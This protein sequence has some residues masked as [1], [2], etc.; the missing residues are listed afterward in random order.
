[1]SPRETSTGIVLGPR[2]TVFALLTAYPFL[3]GFLLGY[4]EAF[5]RLGVPG[6][7]EGWARKVTLGD[8]ALDM[9]VT[10][11]RL[12]REIGD[13]VIRVSGRAA[14]VVGSRGPVDEND[15]RLV[16]I[17]RIAVS[18]EAGGSLVELAGDLRDVTAGMDSAEALALE[19]TLAGAVGEA[20]GAADRDVET[21]AGV[22]ADAAGSQYPRGHPVDTLRREAVMVRRLCADLRAELERLGGSASKRRWRASRSLVERLVRRLSEVEQRYRRQQQAWFPALAV[23]GIEGPAALLGDRQ[24]EA[25][26]SLRRLRLAVSG[27]DAAFVVDTGTRLL[28]LLEDLLSI[29]EQVLVPLAERRLAPGDWAAVREMEDG[30]GW[31]LIPA[32]P[33]WPAS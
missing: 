4:D 9:N 3:D 13:E 20:R 5:R 32:P 8:V 30:L 17:R 6:G 7:R 27:D 31:S 16:E 14:A 22:S 18:L 10:W 23:L 25:L 19:R 28:D 11:R 21:A 24:A 12:V 26:E 29:D 1:M 15:W 33:P 2:T